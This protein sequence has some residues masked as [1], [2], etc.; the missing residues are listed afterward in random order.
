MKGLGLI[1]G[2]FQWFE[3]D[4]ISFRHSKRYG[5]APIAWR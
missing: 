2:C 5:V 3:N 4:R 1:A